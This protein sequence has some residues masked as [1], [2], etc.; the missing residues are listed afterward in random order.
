M[1]T[2]NKDNTLRILTVLYS[3]TFS[4]VALRTSYSVFDESPDSGN[5]ISFFLNTLWIFSLYEIP[6]LMAVYVVGPMVN[7]AMPTLFELGRKRSTAMNSCLN[8]KTIQTGNPD[9]NKTPVKITGTSTTE[10]HQITDL[11]EEIIGYVSKTFAKILT[12]YQIEKLLN[13]LRN[14]NNGKPYEVVEK[15]KLHDVFEFDL[16]HFAWNVCKRIHNPDFCPKKFGFATAELIKESFPL[17]LQNYSV[18]TI[19]C[20]L[21][22]SDA[23][24]KFRLQIID[25]GQPLTPYIFSGNDNISLQEDK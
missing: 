25:V 8:N 7:D 12:S 21:K 17:T 2:T 6:F 10:D 15:R 24:T 11:S 1:D 13:N 9:T 3:V 5:L 20:R 19:K 18:N 14:I 16:I 4:L 23:T 22:D